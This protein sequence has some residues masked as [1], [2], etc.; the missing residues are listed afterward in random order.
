MTITA[1]FPAV[2]LPAGHCHVGQFYLSVARRAYGPHTA[3][4]MAFRVREWRRTP[5]E[6]AILGRRDNA[7]QDHSGKASEGGS[8]AEAGRSGASSGGRSPPEGD[9]PIESADGRQRDQRGFGPGRSGYDRRN[10]PRRRK[11]PTDGI[12]PAQEKSWIGAANLMLRCTIRWRPRR[13]AH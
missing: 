3:K 11:A 7:V 10:F 6:F 8:E 5:R 1:G 13:F 4:S 12:C 9:V 2:Q